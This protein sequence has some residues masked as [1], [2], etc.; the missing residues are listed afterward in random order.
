MFI[1][2]PILLLTSL[3]HAFIY[4]LLFVLLEILPHIYQTTY[5]NLS[6]SLAGLSFVAPWVGNILGV[7]IYFGYFKPAYQAAQQR[8]YK[9]NAA[10]PYPRPDLQLK[11]EAHLPGVILSSLLVPLGM[12]WFALACDR[13]ALHVVV[14]QLSGVPI[15]MGMTLLQLSL[16]NYYIDLYPS[17][18]ASA[19]AA[20]VFARS[21]LATWT[22]TFGFPM[23]N[24][25]G[26]RNASLVL[27]GVGCLG[28]P[29]GVVLFVCGQRIRRAS[30]RAVKEREWDGVSGRWV[31]DKSLEG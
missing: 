28:I 12:F 3:Y 18:S 8:L 31:D 16:S 24:S 17:L 11:P 1:C 29:A 6:L 9:S 20:N 2:E 25:L 14:P 10:L 27:A 22:P 19:L 5:I 30:R 13:P 23:Y 26:A 15:G 4:G 21:V 7:L